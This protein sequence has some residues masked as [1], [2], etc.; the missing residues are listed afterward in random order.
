MLYCI[1]VFFVLVVNALAYTI[2]HHTNFTC[3]EME[4]SLINGYTDERG[5]YTSL[6]TY[7]GPLYICTIAKNVSLTYSFASP[8]LGLGYNTV[9][10]PK[11]WTIFFGMDENVQF[12]YNDVS[13]NSTTSLILESRSLKSPPTVVTFVNRGTTISKI[14][15]PSIFVAVQSTD[16]QDKTGAIIGTTILSLLFVAILV[17]FRN[18]K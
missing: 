6:P 18:L 11:S 13:V 12:F 7:V 2:D 3:P 1:I 17:I 14:L 5:T 4:L 16:G 8:S 9:L 15:L 10:Y